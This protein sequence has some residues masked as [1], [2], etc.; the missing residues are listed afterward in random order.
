[1]ETFCFDIKIGRT[2]KKYFV[3]ANSIETAHRLT[4]DTRRHARIFKN[5]YAHKQTHIK[6]AY[7]E[8]RSVCVCAGAGAYV[9]VRVVEN[10][11]IWETRVYLT[12][13]HTAHC[14]HVCQRMT[15]SSKDSYSDGIICSV[16]FIDHHVAVTAAHTLVCSTPSPQTTFH[17]LDDVLNLVRFI[18]YSLKC[19]IQLLH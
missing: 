5:R 18:Y 2:I 15:E 6:Y 9:W 1:M 11:C 19:V 16:A 7:C 13:G 4:A 17:L 12:T 8:K 14:N 10:N 3:I